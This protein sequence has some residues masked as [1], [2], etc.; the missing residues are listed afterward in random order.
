MKI[1]MVDN[2]D[3]DSISDVLIADNVNKFY[4][5]YIAEALNKKFSPGDYAQSFFKPVDN[6][7]KLYEFM[8]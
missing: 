1:I 4:A 2:F 7:Y 3:R 5:D 8:P 6:D